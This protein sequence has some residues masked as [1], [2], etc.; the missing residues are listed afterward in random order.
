[1]KS[2]AVTGASSMLASALIKKLTGEGVKVLAIVRP[3]S[4]KTGNIPKSP[5]VSVVECDNSELDKFNPNFECDAFFH[6][7]WEGTSSS[8]RQNAQM[9]RRNAQNALKALELGQRM[10]TKFFL[11]AGSQ[12]EYGI[13]NE[14]LTPETP[15]NPLTEYGY[16]KT[17]ASKM[18]SAQCERCGI[19]YAHARILS[20]YGKG[21]NPFTLVS[22][23]IEKMRKNEDTAFTTG[24]QLWDYL[25]SGD[26]AEAFYLMAKHTKGSKIYVLGSGVCR[27]L[28]EYIEIIAEETGY[29][30]EIGFGKIE[31]S[32]ATPQFL[33][34]DITELRKIGF[35]PKIGFREGIRQ[36]LGSDNNE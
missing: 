21:D 34:A 11:T 10:G 9:Q 15:L 16:W 18:C 22:S 13:K 30:K 36:I 35:E 19:S 27:P 28:R 2:A 33:C 12:A 1:M 23:A 24:D 17:E 20:V 32:G 4:K 31:K 29:K 25:Y 5:L 14:S 7:A 8:D 26:A 3:N 6:F